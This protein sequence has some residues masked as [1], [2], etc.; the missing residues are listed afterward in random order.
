MLKSMTEYPKL[1]GTHT[2]QSPTPGPVCGN[3][4]N[5]IV[6]LRAFILFII[7]FTYLNNQFA[8]IQI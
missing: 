8:L 3:T 1:E 2:D 6:C 4:K 7:I 5:L